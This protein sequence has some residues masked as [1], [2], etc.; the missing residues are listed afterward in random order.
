MGGYALTR[1][2]WSSSALK[3]RKSILSFELLCSSLPLI[4][5]IVSWWYIMLMFVVWFLIPWIKTQYNFFSLR[6]QAI[7]TFAAVNLW[8]IF[9]FGTSV[10]QS[11]SGKQNIW[12]WSRGWSVWMI[13]RA[14]L[15]SWADIAYRW[16]LSWRDNSSASCTCGPIESVTASYSP[17]CDFRSRLHSGCH[18]F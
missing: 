2:P 1:S 5:V 18:F 16:T 7:V 11:S 9:I 17:E 3:I 6:F 15:W 8:I 12:C 10:V 4:V 13:R 14:L